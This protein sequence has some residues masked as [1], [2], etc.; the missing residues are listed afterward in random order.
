MNN[1]EKQPSGERKISIVAPF[2]E[3]KANKVESVIEK[4]PP[5]TNKE[6]FLDQLSIIRSETRD[7]VDNPGNFA[8]QLM[9]L[10]SMMV[11]L[12]V[13]EQS[14]LKASNKEEQADG[15]EEELN[16]W[17]GLEKKL[18][19]AEDDGFENF[20]NQ[21]LEGIE[22]EFKKIV[23]DT[24]DFED[25]GDDELGE[26]LS[27]KL[28]EATE[29]A[30][31]DV[32]E[33]VEED[34]EEENVKKKDD[35]DSK[36]E[37]EKRETEK[38]LSKVF[39]DHPE[40]RN[41][42]SVEGVV[43]FLEDNPGASPDQITAKFQEERE[44]AFRASPEILSRANRREKERIRAIN[45]ENRK[46]EALAS[47]YYD[48]PGKGGYTG[49]E[50]LT[51]LDKAEELFERFFTRAY[52][53]Q[54]ENFH[55]S[56]TFEDQIEFSRFM[57][58]FWSENAIKAAA[59]KSGKSVEKMRDESRK[60]LNR[61]SNEYV[62]RAMIFNAHVGIE[63]GWIEPGDYAKSMTAMTSEMWNYVFQKEDQ[64]GV[65]F[66]ASLF[67]NAFYNLLDTN[68]RVEY[69]QIAV[70]PKGDGGAW[71][72]VDEKVREQFILGKKNEISKRMDFLGKRL[73]AEQVSQINSAFEEE[74]P[75]WKITKAMALSKSYFVANLRAPEIA[76]KGTWRR[77]REGG[78][79]GDRYTSGPYEK[80]ARVLDPAEWFIAR[81]QVGRPASA[82]LYFVLGDKRRHRNAKEMFMA[83]KT[84]EF[85][86]DEVFLANLRNMFGI[87]GHM[88]SSGWR[89]PVMGR[90]I[91][92]NNPELAPLLGV[93]IRLQGAGAE[94]NIMR[95]V[96]ENG[97][98]IEDMGEAKRKIWTDALWMNPMQVVHEAQT[99]LGRNRDFS[100]GL[101]DKVYKKSGI[102]KQDISQAREDLQFV[103]A[104]SLSQF[105]V[106][107]D[108]LSSTGPIDV[109]SFL[110]FELLPEERRANAQK[111]FKGIR[112]TM[113]EGVEYKSDGYRRN[114]IHLGRKGLKPT[115]KYGEDTEAETMFGKTTK[116][117]S[118]IH[119]LSEVKSSQGY[120]Q[121]D[122]RLDLL[123][124]EKVG[125]EGWQRRL[126]DYGMAVEALHGMADFF[127]NYRKVMHNTADISDALFEKIISPVKAYNP[128]HGVELAELMTQAVVEFHDPGWLAAS[129]PEPL[130]D[131]YDFFK[132]GQTLSELTMGEHTPYWE[133]KHK[134][135]FIQENMTTG[136][137]VDDS[138]GAD[139]THHV[140]DKMFKKLGATR[141][142]LIVQWAVKN[143]IP[144]A[145]LIGLI[146]GMELKE[147]VEKDLTGS[148]SGGGKG[149]G[150][151]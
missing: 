142:D 93:N 120:G 103:Q 70:L 80:H 1:L 16:K 68:N 149:G 67:E 107:K 110:N 58:V 37:R 15:P 50:I 63:R 34:P 116:Y 72:I 141:T 59:E 88:S 30:T 81:Y 48:L 43:K 114:K 84:G 119:M 66:G 26:N 135:N 109:K 121:N 94:G 79:F 21:E 147:L 99:I 46:E 100:G 6:G 11:R 148:S 127:E 65:S 144:N 76:A 132:K 38:K 96:N 10:A 91:L 118:S 35:F 102:G 8:K 86:N 138:H 19:E 71:S 22:D 145:T 77:E 53:Q 124:F 140:E 130:D 85:K 136:M 73:N 62:G 31:E 14:V 150:H 106:N 9:F 12:T 51:D 89:G 105:K 49:A 23:G 60:M 33:L 126:R 56:M 29:E 41:D 24:K 7:H 54:T 3:M 75:E 44:K 83:W 133:V 113:N 78:F 36:K 87:G 98:K 146:F 64:A 151:H 104:Q 115:I 52:A 97:N 101:W 82:M 4:A 128:H 42:P 61:F 13:L 111:L 117:N 17:L 32:V 139:S 18:T 47:G 5:E 122:V 27:D 57:D 2:V 69:D 95:P 45:D 134:R 90:T 25:V 125:P 20:S 112:E 108:N 123:E 137:Y 40:L 39:R 129:L 143:G 74:W 131:M 92:Q 55:R 28:V